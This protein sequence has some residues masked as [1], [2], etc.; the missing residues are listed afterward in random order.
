MNQKKGKWNKFFVSELDRFIT[1]FRAQQTRTD[2][3]RVEI[4]KYQRIHHLRDHPQPGVP[5]SDLWDDF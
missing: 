4:A 1:S 2:A 5:V 3:Q